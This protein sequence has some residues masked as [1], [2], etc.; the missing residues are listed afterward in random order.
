[1]KSEHEVIGAAVR[2]ILSSTPLMSISRQLLIEELS[3]EYLEL[4]ESGEHAD[5]ICT[6]ESA[7]RKIKGSLN[8]N[9]IY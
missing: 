9:D 4:L 1:M 7:L 3:K 5:D 8:I 6:Y 2:K